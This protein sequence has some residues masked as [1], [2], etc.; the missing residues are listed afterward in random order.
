MVTGMPRPVLELTSTANPRVRQ[1]IELRKRRGRDRMG[2]TLVEGH[3]EIGLALAGGVRPRPLY[4]CE[5]L[6][7]E[8]DRQRLVG[9]ALGRGAELILVGRK[10]FDRVAY[11]ESPDGWL[12]LVDTPGTELAG[13]RLPVDP[14]LLVCVGVE[15]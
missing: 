7:R 12:A 2:L 1:L 4:L 8:P 15:K 9:L 5:E 14:L 10:V 6:V 13:L 3:D 11:R